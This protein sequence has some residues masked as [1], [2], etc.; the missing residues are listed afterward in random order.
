[1]DTWIS[2]LVRSRS[3][4][5]VFAWIIA[6]GLM[7]F[8]GFSKQ[9]YIDNFFKGPFDMGLA[10]LNNISK[11]SES[12]FYFARVTGDKVIKTGMRE[13]TVKKSHGVVVSSS[14]SAKYYVL[15]VGDRLLLV[16]SSSEPQLTIEGA[17]QEIPKKV[18]LKL[19][20]SPEI[21][22]FR[23]LF[24]P[25]YLDETSFRTPGYVGIGAL[26]LVIFLF[27]KYFLPAW[28]SWRDPVAHPLLT[29]VSSWGDPAA[30]SAQIERESRAPLYAKRGWLLTDTYIIKRKFF[31]VDVL[32]FSDL[33]WAYKK[34]TTHRI[35]FIIPIR[36]TYE[37]TLHCLG[38][39][40]S[41][42]GKENNINQVLKLA[43]ERAPWAIFTYSK[44]L[45]Q[46]FRKNL[47]Q[48]IAEIEQRKRNWTGKS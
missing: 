1:M 24:F 12:L 44:A 14:V 48:V 5:V 41:V 33:L 42:D 2:Q 29:R 22:P 46:L 20:I 11:I 40:A 18:A 4:R 19:S 16:K 7:L 10:E 30:I 13:V 34:I 23:Q 39:K 36:R 43:V 9:R 37:A 25:F 32:R 27:V 15:A 3:S 31:S 35:Y 17:L 8:W 21:L 26:L 6:L 45:A 28:R 38:G 47:P